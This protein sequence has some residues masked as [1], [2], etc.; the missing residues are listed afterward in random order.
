MS[1]HCTATFF[2]LQPAADKN[3]FRPGTASRVRGVSFT[4]TI[5]ERAI[6]LIVLSSVKLLY[7]ITALGWRIETSRVKPLPLMTIRSGRHCPSTCLWSAK[8][9]VQSA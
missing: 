6:V 8:V 4:V 3:S 2:A 5:F 9:M 7:V 1:V